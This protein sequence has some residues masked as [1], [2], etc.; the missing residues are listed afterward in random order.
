MD[1]R[2]YVAKRQ[3]PRP[4]KCF[5]LEYSFV[6]ETVTWENSRYLA[7]LPLVFSLN[8]VWETSAEIPYRWRV[9]THPR[10][11]RGGQSG[12]GKRRDESFQAQTEKPLATDSHRTISKRS[13]ENLLL[14]EQKKCIC[15]IVPNRRTAS[16]EFF[17]W[18]RTRLLLGTLR[19]SDATA[20]R[21][22][23]KRLS[24]RKPCKRCYSAY[25]RIGSNFPH[26]HNL[27][28]YR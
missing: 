10:R 6:R 28:K 19:S 21:T 20:T 8:D 18:I 14:I 5:A 25:H 4:G 15:I 1:L 9:T 2:A 22:S 17:S 27:V 7:T 26:R 11:P 16:P 13:S 24:M 23:L 3:V 12:R